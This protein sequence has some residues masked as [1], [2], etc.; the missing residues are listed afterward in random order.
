[1]QEE[2]L[3]SAPALLTGWY[4]SYHPNLF[5]DD[6]GGHLSVVPTWS[7]TP[8]SGTGKWEGELSHHQV[9]HLDSIIA[10]VPHWLKKPMPGLRL[11]REIQSL[12]AHIQAH[13]DYGA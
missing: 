13:E 1:M 6:G 8:G 10:I 5:K 4:M 3:F 11:P 12:C 9:N 2:N 7:K